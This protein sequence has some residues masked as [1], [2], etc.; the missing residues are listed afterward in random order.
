[1]AGLADGLLS[2]LLVAVPPVMEVTTEAASSRG[3][4][5]RVALEDDEEEEEDESRPDANAPCL[6][7]DEVED[8]GD[9][10]DDEEEDDDGEE[11][12]ASTG[13]I[14]L[15]RRKAAT[16]GS[17]LALVEVGL[18]LRLGAGVGAAS[19]T[20]SGVKGFCSSEAS[21]AGSS[22]AQSAWSTTSACTTVLLP[23]G[24]SMET[25]VMSSAALDSAASADCKAGETLQSVRRALRRRS[26][27]VRL[28]ILPSLLLLP[29]LRLLGPVATKETS[30]S[31]TEPAT[32]LASLTVS[33][34]DSSGV[35]PDLQKTNS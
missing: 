25:A 3:S 27:R 32:S 1:M 24:E 29:T 34:R 8:A 13:G 15:G 26:T 2:R 31:S 28:L 22:M 21:S 14:S 18:E 20:A 10:A 35:R 17:S 7:G 12:E 30:L 11:V 5:G 16:S 19:T 9:E 6:S 33:F 23:T 4:A